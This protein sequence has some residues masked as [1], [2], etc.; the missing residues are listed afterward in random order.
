M[1]CQK[2][3]LGA[4]IAKRGEEILM[5]KQQCYVLAVNKDIKAN[6]Q[7]ESMMYAVSPTKRERVNSGDYRA[8]AQR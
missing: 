2:E 8:V 1:K 4:E 6:H 5:L 7:R 3:Q